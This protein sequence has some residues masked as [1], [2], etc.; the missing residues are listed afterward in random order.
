MNTIELLPDDEKSFE[1]IEEEEFF[2]VKD[3]RRIV[4]NQPNEFHHVDDVFHE[5][6][7]YHSVHL[8]PYLIEE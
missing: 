4:H 2:V 5:S 1:I 8:N 7:R 6:V 3:V